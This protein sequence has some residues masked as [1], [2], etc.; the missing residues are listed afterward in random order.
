[1]RVAALVGAFLAAC[2]ASADVEC[3]DEGFAGL[4]CDVAQVRAA[5]GCAHGRALGVLRRLGR[6]LAKDVA[7]A[8][9]ADEQGRSAAVLAR[10]FTAERR[11]ATLAGRVAAL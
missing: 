4:A 3:P 10:L 6:R 8:G 11:V 9:K 7:R 2:V 5:T 1:M